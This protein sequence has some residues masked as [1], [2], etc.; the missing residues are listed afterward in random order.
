MHATRKL[1]TWLAVICVMSFAVLGWVGTEIYLTAP[2]IPKQVISTKGDVLFS[3]GQVQRGQ[4]AWLSAG[5]QQ[6]GS[7][8]GHGSYVAPDW[9]ADWLH[10]EA[11]A[12]RSVWAQKDFGKPFEQLSVGQQGELSAR[13]KAEMRGNTYD[14]ATGAITLS[15]ERAEAVQQ[16]VKH[17]TDL[18]GDAPS[19]DKLREQYA[20]N[21]GTLPDPA[22]LKALPA[23]IFWSAWAA[24]TDRPNE[25]ELSYTSNWP[26]EPL[27]DNTPTAGAEIGRA[28]V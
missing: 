7:V 22:D 26:H 11:L 3:E 8:W 6:L 19:L 27:V 2:P 13:L 24:A 16:V 21:A 5:G 4:E 1:W 12:L 23:F 18:F 25:S 10:R 14:A 20:M 28:H 17:Y 9:S 15:P